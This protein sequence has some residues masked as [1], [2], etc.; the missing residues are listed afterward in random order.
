MVI[1]SFYKVQLF[2]PIKGGFAK[3]LEGFSCYYLDTILD[4]M[5]DRKTRERFFNFE[6]IGIPSNIPAIRKIQETEAD[7]ILS[8]PEAINPIV[9]SPFNT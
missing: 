3:K 7:Y 5:E 6:F 4:L 1:Q 2:I 9:I 8:T